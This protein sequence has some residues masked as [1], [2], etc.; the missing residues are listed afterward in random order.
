MHRDL[1]SEEREERED[2]RNE[3]LQPELLEKKPEEE[4]IRDD[5]DE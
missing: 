5:E 1:T 4:E 2:K 3:L